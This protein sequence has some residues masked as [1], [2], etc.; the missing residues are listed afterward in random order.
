MEEKT[1]DKLMKGKRKGRFDDQ[2]YTEFANLYNEFKITGLTPKEIKAKIKETIKCGETRYYDFLR[3][4]RKLGFIT[5]KDEVY[6]ESRKRAS[7]F[8]HKYNEG[9]KNNDDEPPGFTSLIKSAAQGVPPLVVSSS[10]MVA[11]FVHEGYTPRPIV[12]DESERPKIEPD[13]SSLTPR[14]EAHVKKRGIFSAIAAFFRG[15]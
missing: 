3:E 9:R 4:S 1:L 5:D 2:F 7:E 6:A 14:S 8:M 12:E 13:E 10:T 11:N 15:K